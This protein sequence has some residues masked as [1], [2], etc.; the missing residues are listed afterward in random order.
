[1]MSQLPYENALDAAQLEL[2]QARQALLRELA[3]YPHPIS[4]CD[5]QYVRLV[6]DRT[7]ISECLRALA[8]RPFVATPRVLE[9]TGN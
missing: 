9:A 1:M 6:S 2:E 7:R 4:G 8:S 5:A 3:D